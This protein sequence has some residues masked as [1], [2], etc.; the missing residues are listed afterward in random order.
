MDYWAQF[1]AVALIHVI[2]RLSGTGKSHLSLSFWN[3][4]SGPHQYGS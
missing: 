1:P 3:D 2:E 4:I